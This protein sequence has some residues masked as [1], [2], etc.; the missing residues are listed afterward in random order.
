MGFVFQV[1]HLTLGSFSLAV[2]CLITLVL[3]RGPTEL[4]VLVVRVGGDF[5]TWGPVPWRQSLSLVQLLSRV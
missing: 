2:E 3:S 1:L 5:L 4:G